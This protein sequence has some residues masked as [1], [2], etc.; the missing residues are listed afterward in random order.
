MQDFPSKPIRIITSAVGSDMDLVTRLIAQGISGPLGQ[1]VTVENHGP[2]RLAESVFK[3]PPDGHTLLVSPQTLWVA[4]LVQDTPYDPVRDFAPI[5]LAA[6]SPLV[7]F[8][9][10]S[11]AANSIQELIALA[12]SRS[13]ELSYASGLDGST[14]HLGGG[15]FNYMAGVN[16]VRV[17]YK[18]GLVGIKDL[19][20]GKVQLMI[21]SAGMGMEQVKLGKLRALAVTSAQRSAAVPGLPTVAASG[22]PGYEVV[23]TIG[24]FAPA[25]TPAAIIKRLNHEMVRALNQLDIKEK[26]LDVGVE[27]VASSSEEFAAKIKSEM[28]KWGKLFKD[29]GI[30]VVRKDQNVCK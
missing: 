20:A 16:I 29:I 30:T 10:P 8:V 14:S 11:V 21:P 13:G 23:Q 9:H 25:E 15:L 27:V 2:D 7:F 4:P 24:I 1:P 3:A 5:S 22:L 12:K 28:T 6:T 17:P 18:S 26:L 19:I